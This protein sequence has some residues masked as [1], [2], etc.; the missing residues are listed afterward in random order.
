M[1]TF[2]SFNS[3]GDP[4]LSGMCSPAGLWHGL[5]S[6][7]RNRRAMVLDR[8]GVAAGWR[9]G[10]RDSRFGFE[11]L[12][13]RQ[14]LVTFTV[15]NLA[16][17]GMGSLRQAVTDANNLAGADV[18]TF[19]AGARGTI[20]LSGTELVLAGEL[21]IAGPGASDL[22]VSGNS[23]SRI[24]RVLPGA[25]VSISGLAVS[26]GYSASGGGGVSN[27]GTLAVTNCTVSSNW[28][29]SGG[30]VYNAGSLSITGSS[31]A[32]N[33]AQLA[34]GGIKNV[35]SLAITGSTITG[36]SA[37][38]ISYG[39]GGGIENTGTLTISNSTI[40]GNG[41]IEY[42]GGIFAS[43]T[44]D[45]TNSTISSNTSQPGG[46]GGGLFLNTLEP[47]T[48]R[49]STIAGNLG[50]GG[51]HIADGALV[52]LSSLVAGNA[53]GDLL[54]DSLGAGSTNNLV[55]D[56]AHAGGLTDGVNGNLVGV[57]PLLSALADNGGPTRTMGLQAGSPALGTGLNQ[58]NLTSDQ[59]GGPFARGT[60]VDIGAYQRQSLALVVDTNSDA[61]DGN[62]SA[63]NLS[64][65]EA[66][67]ACNANSLADAITFA[68]SLNA[69][70]IT[71]GGSELLVFG[72]LTITGPSQNAL[73]ISGNNATR[74]FE[75]ASSASVSI[76][77]LTI[78]DGHS[79][80][81]AGGVYINANATLN[82]VE[83]A[84]S[85]HTSSGGAGGINNDGTLTITNSTISGNTA[86]SSH[87][88]GINN[89]GTLTITG[90]TISQNTAQSPYSGGG[91]NNFGQLTIASSTIYGNTALYGGGVNNSGGTFT[92]TNTNILQNSAP[93]ANGGAV[94]NYGNGTGTIT[95]CTISGNSAE[96]GAGV[97]NDSSTLTISGSAISGN[98]ANA[99]GGGVYNNSLL[100]ITNSTISGNTA[101][102][103]G[104]GV[105]ASDGTLTLTNSIVTGDSAPY[106]GGVAIVNGALIV[107][108]CT[109]SANT[110]SV[111]GGGLYALG[112]SPTIRNSTIGANLGSGGIYADQSFPLLISCIVAGN[113]GGD[114]LNGGLSA[115]SIN[116][117]VQDAAH[118]GG[119]TNGVNGNIV[120][121]DPLLSALA[122]NG[123]T[124]KTMALQAGSPAIGKG[125]N[126][127][128]LT[129]D[130]RG[131]LFARGASADIG[132]YQRQSFAFVVDSAVDESDGDFGAGDLSLREAIE[133]AGP[134]PGND[135]ITF[136]ASLNGQTIT[137]GGTELT[138]KGDLTITGPGAS[139]LS[140][141]GNNASRVF[142]IA[143]G[144]NVSVSG[145]AIKHG[146]ALSGGGGFYNQGTLT[147]TDSTISEST[148]YSG[149]GVLNKGTLT[150][151]GST[152]SGNPAAYG[153]GIY[154]NGTVTITNSTISANSALY[155]GGVDSTADTTSIINST[156]SGNSAQ[157]TGGGL[158]NYYCTLAVTNSTIWGNSAPTAGGGIGTS[159]GTVT[160][161]NTTIAA[162]LGNGGLHIDGGAPVLVSC[163][164]AGNVGG[165]ILKGFL[166]AG[167]TNNLIQDAAHAGGLTNGV[168]ANIVGVNPLLSPLSNNGGPTLTMALQAGSPA[169]NKGLNP[170][171]LTTDQRGTGFARLHGTAIDIGAI[172]FSAIPSLSSLTVSSASIA[173]GQVLTLTANS[174]ADADGTI[175]RV[176]FYRD[177]NNNGIGDTSELIGSDSN[178]AGGYTFSFNT[179]GQALGN[180]NFFARAVDNDAYVSAFGFAAA[181]IINAVPTVSNLTTSAAVFVIGQSMTLTA[182][183]VADGDG[184]I[185]RVD[186]YRDANANGVA[187]AGEQLGSDSNP[188]GGYTYTL[189][190]AQSGVIPTGTARFLAI[191]IDNNGGTSAPRPGSA[192]AQSPED[193]FI[194]V[195]TASPKDADGLVDGD[196][197]VATLKSA[198]SNV[199]TSDAYWGA[200]NN[201]FQDK[202]GDVW[203]L[204]QGGDVHKSTT[205]PG[206][207]RWVLTNLT[208]AAGLSGTM[209]FA[210]GSLSGITTGWNAFNVQG[211]QD[212]KL[213][214]LWWSPEASAETYVD[215]DGTT[216][217]GQGLGLRGNGWS[218]SSISDALTP[219]NGAVAA[220]PGPFRA[221]S[222]SQGNSR[223]DFDPRATYS[224]A[225]NGMSVVLVDTSDRVYLATFNV[226]QQL[227]V[228]GTRNDLNG[229]WLIERMADVP[230]F[231][232][233]GLEAQE[234]AF[235][236]QIIAAA[237]Q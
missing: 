112:A 113:T 223:T 161:R 58:A 26:N 129:T 23:L 74:V 21:T 126:P 139:V 41:S 234:P 144:A 57:D 192:M 111:Q 6:D 157:Y 160:I 154:N 89:T 140:I 90:S 49:N 34:G 107:T 64:L 175:I 178:P 17:T 181:T 99:E 190:T 209:R 5:N 200:Q 76:S 85:G 153:G 201:W 218:L 68:S 71:L 134:N 61:L 152:I 91:V 150:I 228:D 197:I 56:A 125:L 114:I 18:I 128:N 94:H 121:I 145:L 202:N 115:G 235:E 40:S 207:H 39:S 195:Y 147:I 80:S 124:T 109:I 60:S 31:I 230:S 196:A 104:G 92:I 4:L 24:F 97:T 130:Q 119:L 142:Q 75:V 73:S 47:M 118:A 7:A 212:G 229:L 33:T 2:G 12:E 51:I 183:G 216:K 65:R 27:D 203:V 172:E 100:T 188:G 225:N 127:A 163:I 210:P 1:K 120:G 53:G 28:A 72:D 171:N 184:T 162:N 170:A 236:Q 193:H 169:V 232:W 179:S 148:G 219:I 98:T 50:N 141:S 87:G 79:A 81:L 220:P 149:G 133:A 186:F 214:A 180:V 63:G 59:R 159:S 20:T 101:V 66:I 48:V 204:W 194:E 189:T 8:S 42:G 22:T 108:N 35:G 25:S 9:K 86:S 123:G 155:G 16:D 10:R 14:L 151:T 19:D 182:N 198:V 122:D 44:L 131:G 177:A 13:S 191:A 165:D 46:Q 84:L 116:N 164:V 187:D 106:G 168:N 95:N 15:T 55:Q 103:R 166:G 69:T 199:A 93:G 135:T 105:H 224:T 11:S 43:R 226:W 83:V 132:A 30:A 174:V 62:Y 54:G 233:F 215:L 37:Q 206:Q 117:L 205:L 176:D 32:S 211:I 156:I 143:A 167:S 70:T 213:L 137:L 78:K 77:K 102:N 227:N 208:D 29:H 38:D 237:N 96:L 185:T 3:E 158:Y 136:A 231:K 222:T 217:H 173:R 221:Y 88:G 36:N 138:A 52:M 45:I 110:A 82:L 146:N 67:G